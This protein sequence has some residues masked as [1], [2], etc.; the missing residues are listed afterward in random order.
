MARLSK[1]GH[2]FE[3]LVDPDLALRFRKGEPIS[4]ENILAS[5]EIFAD[6]RK[7]ERAKGENLMKV[8]NTT[9]FPTVVTSI[10]KHGEIQLTTE[11]RRRFVE[12]KKKEIAN[13]IS[14][15]GM[16]PRTKLPHPPQRV[17]NAMEQA[18]VGIDPF[19]PA[20]DQVNEV[21][22]KIQP[23]IAISLERIDIAI[24]VPIEF[25][26]RANAEVRKIAPVKSEEWKNDAWIAVLEIPAGMQADIYESLNK[27][28]AGR[29]EVKIVKEYKI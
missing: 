15:Q 21:L 29:V 8:F 20:R 18:K 24:R 14:R 19:R 1:A 28:T 11:Q 2:N 25:A 3:I 23:I 13:I 5:Q 7:G 17:L 22:S 10:L 4:I 12:E 6:A 26:G 27:L 9:D 16:D